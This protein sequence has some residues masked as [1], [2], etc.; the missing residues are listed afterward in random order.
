MKNINNIKLR[1]NEKEALVELKN[2]IYKLN[3]KIEIILYGSKARGDDVEFSD[4]DILILTDKEI[5]KKLKDDISWIRYKI[6]LKYD[7]VI[8]LDF[9]N[10]DFWESPLANA[11]PF[12]WN[13]DREGVLI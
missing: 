12:H 13:I 2:E 9:E 6:E 10:R 8:S 7:V 4:A 5:S 3:N 1:E 11:M